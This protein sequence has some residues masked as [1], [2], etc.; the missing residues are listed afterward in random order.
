MTVP[1][2]N[3]HDL[4]PQALRMAQDCKNKRLAMTMEYLAVGS[5]IIMAG[6]AAAHLMKDLFGR[7]ESQGRSR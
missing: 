5:I 3:L 2:Y 1:V 4:G 7:S 6:A